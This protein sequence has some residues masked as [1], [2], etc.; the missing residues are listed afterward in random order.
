MTKNKRR[1]VF[2]AGIRKVTVHASSFENACM[3]ARETL[4]RRC[5]KGGAEPPVAWT[6]ELIEGEKTP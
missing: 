5:E 2:R 3:S 6:L 4:D 1:Y